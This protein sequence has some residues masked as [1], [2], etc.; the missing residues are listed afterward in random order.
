MSGRGPFRI[1]VVSGAICS[2]KSAL[3]GQLADRH[4]ATVV[5]TRR[6]VAGTIRR[7]DPDRP[8]MQRAGERLDKAQGGEWVVEAL[9]RVVYASSPTGTA[10]GLFVVDCVRTADQIA[11]ARRAFGT[12]VYHVHLTARPEVLRER[13]VARAGGADAA[14]DYDTLSVAAPR[15]GSKT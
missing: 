15:R 1:V 8:A 3:V 2:G 14:V 7:R 11:A 9:Q 4:E 6:I 10:S 13:Y 12:A 5:S